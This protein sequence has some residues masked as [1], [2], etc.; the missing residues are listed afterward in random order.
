MI[1]LIVDYLLFHD[2]LHH[3]PVNDN[4]ILLTWEVVN[5]TTY[6]LLGTVMRIWHSYVRYNCATSEQDWTSLCGWQKQCVMKHVILWCNIFVIIWTIKDS[7]FR[8]SFIVLHSIWLLCNYMMSSR[9]NGLRLKMKRFESCLLTYGTPYAMSKIL[10]FKYH[11]APQTS[12]LR[13]I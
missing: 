13:S 3:L 7:F 8:I 6:H 12:E 11:E 10:Y 1:I 2:N 9:N 5:G 4:Y